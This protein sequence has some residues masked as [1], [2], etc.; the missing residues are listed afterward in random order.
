MVELADA[1]VAEEVGVRE[2]GDAALT[3]G[4]GHR[5]RG[6]WRRRGRRGAG[7]DAGA[8]S[9]AERPGAV[10][11]RRGDAGEEVGQDAVAD[12][13]GLDPARGAGVVLV[14][15]DGGALD[16]DP[17]AGE[18][19]ADVGAVLVLL[20]L[21]ED[22]QPAAPGDELLDRVELGVGEARGATDGRLPLRVRGVG[23]HEGVGAFERGGVERA[24]G[25]GGDREVA[26]RERTGGDRQG[27]VGRVGA[28]HRLRLLWADRPGL[29]VGLVEEDAGGL[30]DRC[31]HCVHD[32]D[33]S[34]WLIRDQ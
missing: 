5:E 20:G 25:V 33:G 6:T 9:R 15:L 4:G 29:A 10:E 18:E 28:L 23:D 19:L 8:V 17:E 32:D 11:R 27:G 7:D 34:G 22:D 21:D 3:M 12:Q 2:H 14:V 31:G 16:L 30:R 13:L 1:V 26:L 24:A